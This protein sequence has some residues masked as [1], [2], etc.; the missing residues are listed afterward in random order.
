MQI[1][2]PK[3]IKQDVGSIILRQTSSFEY[4]DPVLM[5]PMTKTITIL[6]MGQMGS[7]PIPVNWD[8]SPATNEQFNQY[9][10]MQALIKSCVDNAEDVK[11]R[12]LEIALRILK[13][14]TEDQRVNFVKMDFMN[15]K[16]WLMDHIRT[17]KVYQQF[18]LYNSTKKLKSLSQALNT[19]ILD[20][21]KYTHGQLCFIRPNYDFALEYI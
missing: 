12:I 15:L 7:D 17:S 8:I 18:S 14:K 5:I 21:N 6:T 2:S 1:G 3:V 11:G 13:P 9:A 20:R 19:F 4:V 16:Q 10:G